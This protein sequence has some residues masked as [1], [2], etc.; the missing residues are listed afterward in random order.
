[1]R[2]MAESINSFLETSPR[3]RQR[4]YRRRISRLRLEFF[5]NHHSDYMNRLIAM[6][7]DA[8]GAKDLEV[9]A[10]HGLCTLQL[11]I[12]TTPA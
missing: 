9:L 2:N 10:H 4:P 11:V 1:M 8:W 7:V 5:A 12:H 6:A 3:S